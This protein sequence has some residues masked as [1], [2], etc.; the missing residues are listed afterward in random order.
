MPIIFQTS[1]LHARP[2][3]TIS[4]II[5]FNIKPDYIISLGIINYTLYILIILIYNKF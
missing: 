5:R 4:L 1:I 3:T 2:S